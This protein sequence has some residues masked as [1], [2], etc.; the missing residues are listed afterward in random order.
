MC[1]I[2]N[3]VKKDKNNSENWVES[4]VNGDNGIQVEGFNYSSNESTTGL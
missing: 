4:G 1:I 2:E 3:G